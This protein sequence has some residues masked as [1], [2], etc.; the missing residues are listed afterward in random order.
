LSNL[1]RREAP[2][3]IVTDAGLRN[4][5][6]GIRALGRAGV[7]V[8]ALAERRRAAGRRSRFSSR[9]ADFGSACEEPARFAEE[10]R[11]LAAKLGA[12]SQGPVVVYPGSEEAIEAC[13]DHPYR[14][15]SWKL[16]WSVESTQGLRDKERLKQ[17][18]ASAGVRTPETLAAG[19]PPE[20]LESHLP[21]PCLIKPLG[22][23]GGRVRQASTAEE[24]RRILSGWEHPRERL[25]LQER[26]DGE[27]VSLALVVD[28]TAL[29]VA[30]FQHRALATWPA[31]AGT[32]SSAESEAVSEDL[33]SPALALLREAEHRG[34]AQLQFLRGDGRTALID[35]N[36]GFPG[37]LPLALASGVNLPYASLQVAL[38]GDVEPVLRYPTGRRFRWLEADLLAAANGRPSALFR[39]PGSVGAAWALDDPVP[40]AILAAES[41]A[42][43]AKRI[44]SSRR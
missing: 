26:V 15:A 13:L 10:L 9:D 3:A 40:G 12:N 35:V 42:R 14:D 2:Q 21:A 43:G 18:A 30:A 16:P 28:A 44:L 22:A 37:S 39:R 4:V 6:A 23:G 5:V 7:D 32:V 19:S 11:A 17:I 36:C 41:V 33:L 8:L 34:F 20:L 29:V 31:E 24:L 38:G 1:L 25:I 27:L